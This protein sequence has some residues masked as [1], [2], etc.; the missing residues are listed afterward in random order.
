MDLI[1][2][3]GFENIC[4]DDMIKIILNGI[5]LYNLIKIFKSCKF[6]SVI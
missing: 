1:N 6:N 4:E 5:V 2:N 3:S